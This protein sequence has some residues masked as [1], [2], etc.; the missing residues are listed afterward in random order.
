MDSNHS[1][2]DLDRPFTILATP[3]G[4]VLST[5]NGQF[6]LQTT[7]SD[8]RREIAPETLLGI[9]DSDPRALSMQALNL[10]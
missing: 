9:T 6:L 4:L 5:A 7:V 2:T 8:F 10:I 3:K 1:T